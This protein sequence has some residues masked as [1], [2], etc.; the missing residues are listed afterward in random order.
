[1]ICM[2]NNIRDMHVLPKVH[3]NKCHAFLLIYCLTL[4]F[5]RLKSVKTG[6]QVNDFLTD[7]YCQNL[8]LLK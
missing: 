7:I 1:M 8:I 6:H 5:S 2:I 4:I 3:V